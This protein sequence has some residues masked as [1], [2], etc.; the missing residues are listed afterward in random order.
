M[1]CA[2]F[3]RT[4]TARAVKMFSPKKI[5]QYFT[6]VL[7]LPAILLSTCSEK[8]EY[9]DASDYEKLGAS[10]RIS[11][12]ITSVSP[13]DNSSDVTVST[14]IA[15]TFNEKISTAT[16]T[17]NTSDTNCSGSFQLSSDNFSSCTKMSAVPS[18]S[19]LSLIHI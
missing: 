1:I 11:P 16:V 6:A 14:S 3:S 12:T 19:N 4:I 13:V 10:D 9:G 18:V 8:S 7:I 2:K 17:T 5:T 15:V